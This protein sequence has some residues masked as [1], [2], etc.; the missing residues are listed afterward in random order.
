MGFIK[1][2]LSKQIKKT[3]RYDV[4]DYCELRGLSLS[5]LYRGYISKKAREV[6]KKDGISV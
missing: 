3:T 2:E 5:S 1:R 6:L 4:K